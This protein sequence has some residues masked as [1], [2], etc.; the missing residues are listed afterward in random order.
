M[1]GLSLFLMAVIFAGRVFRTPLL[2][3]PPAS[4]TALSLSLA[5]P[6]LTSR[7]GMEE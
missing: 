1:T 2:G 3:R 7:P 6:A 5:A 4:A